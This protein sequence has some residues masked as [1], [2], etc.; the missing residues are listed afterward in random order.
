MECDLGL[1]DLFA[2]QQN[3]IALTCRGRMREWKAEEFWEILG[4]F[5]D[6]ASTLDLGIVDRIGCV[7]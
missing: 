5:G 2:G 4:D 1:V 6:G 3:G 7:V